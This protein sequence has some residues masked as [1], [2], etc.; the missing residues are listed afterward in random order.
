MTT[1]ERKSKTDPASMEDRIK[2]V[3]SRIDELKVNQQPK[4]LL[5]RL[6]TIERKVAVSLDSNI[7]IK[8]NEEFN[9]MLT[10]GQEKL[11]KWDSMLEEQLEEKVKTI[12]H[13]VTMKKLM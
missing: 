9:R 1:F 7:A 5:E 8:T 13:N 3:E 2:Q 11:K 6:E 12:K 10:K 4:D